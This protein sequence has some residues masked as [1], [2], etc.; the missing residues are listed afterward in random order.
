MFG[1][2]SAHEAAEAGGFLASIGVDNYV[3]S[4]WG[5]ILVLALLS[6]LVTRNLKQIPSGLQNI[7][8]AV[9]EAVMGLLENILGSERTRKYFPLLGTFFLFILFSNYIGL[10]PLAGEHPYQITESITVNPL[11]IPPTANLSVTAALAIIVFFS[12]H[13]FGIASKGIGYFAH[14]LKPMWFMLPLNIIEELVRPV[15]LAMRLYGN[16]FGHELVVATLFILLPYLSPVPIQLLGALTG[17]IQAMVFTLLASTYIAGAT[18][19][20]EAH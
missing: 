11:Y 4:A 19:T 5:I 14:F 17:L 20:S 7:V 9:L 16:I 15:S 2:T 12:T 8:E 10:L 18:E 6:F 3:L 13:I 1:V